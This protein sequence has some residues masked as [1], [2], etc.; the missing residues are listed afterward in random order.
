MQSLFS[1]NTFSTHLHFVCRFC[2]PFTSSAFPIFLT[3]FHLIFATVVTQILARTTDMMK[4]V[5][6]SKDEFIKG[7][8]PI[9]VFFSLSL[10]FS[11]YTYLYLSVSFIQMLK[12][13]HQF[14]HNSFIRLQPPVLSSY[15]TTFSALHSPQNKSYSMFWS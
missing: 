13:S 4:D 2:L 11:N 5:S 12:V 1:I 8:L 15:L 3:S 10:V 9:G 14:G 7:V 6:M